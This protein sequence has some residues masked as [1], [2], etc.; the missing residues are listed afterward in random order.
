MVIFFGTLSGMF[1]W[2]KNTVKTTAVYHSS[3]P[4]L[5]LLLLLLF[6]VAVVMTSHSAHCPFGHCCG[7]PSPRAREL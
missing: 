5:L 1:L 6:A 2:D 4:L 3:L 7:R